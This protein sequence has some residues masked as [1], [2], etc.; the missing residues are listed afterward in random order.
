M[1]TKKSRPPV[2][3]SK[4]KK[5]DEEE[6]IGILPES[7]SKIRASRENRL[8]RLSDFLFK[9]AIESFQIRKA[10]NVFVREELYALGRKTYF[11]RVFILARNIS[12]EKLKENWE[13]SSYKSTNLRKPDCREYFQKHFDEIVEVC[14][15]KKSTADHLTGLCVIM[16]THTMLLIGGAED[17]IANFFDQLSEM[18]NRLF[19]I[20]KVFLVDDIIGETYFNCFY[21]RYGPAININEKFS[22]ATTSD[23]Q[24]MAVQHV[25]IKQ[26]F[27]QVIETLAAE[28]NK[29]D[30]PKNIPADPFLLP[31][32]PY[33]KLLPEIQRIELVLSAD[34]FYHSVQSFALT[35]K[36][37]PNSQ[38]ESA[39]YWPIQ[40][41]FMPLT[42]F[43]RSEFDVNL[44]FGDYGKDEK[45][46][47][48]KAEDAEEKA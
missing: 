42:V 35:Y 10:L 29:E 13:N 28:I 18:H 37:V 23:H 25:K 26:K 3:S 41:N 16:D 34:K 7:L 32:D 12:A 6:P 33:Y 19:E 44:T 1:P 47:E 38:D 27:M 39:L 2:R 31:A 22:P 21:S 4:S 30:E 48:E 20:S 15:R 24:L 45:K 11:Q 9:T 5:K 43:E 8:E 40:N 46:E 17:M 36:E 14:E